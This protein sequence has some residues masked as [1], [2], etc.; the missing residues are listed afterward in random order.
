[1]RLETDNLFDQSVLCEAKLILRYMYIR[2]LLL[3]MFGKFSKL[4]SVENMKFLSQK[5][6]LS[7]QNMHMQIRLLYIF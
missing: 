7:C 5:L 6:F 4:A 3:S 1:M 2:V